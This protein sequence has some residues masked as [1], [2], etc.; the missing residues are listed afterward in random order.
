MTRTDFRAGSLF[1]GAFSICQGDLVIRHAALA[2]TLLLAAGPGPVL[3]QATDDKAQAPFTAGWR[4]GFVI[5]SEKGD[6]RLQIGG[7]LQADARF[8]PGD[9]RETFNDTFLIRRARPSLRARLGQHFE[10]YLN[11]DFAGG[12]LV[13]QD[14]YL[15]TIFAPSFRIR[16]GKMK[17]PFG[18]ERLQSSSHMLFYERALTSNIAPNRDLGV[19]VLGEISRGLVGYA[20]AVTNGVPDGGIADS[21]TSDSKDVTGRI[22]VKPFSRRT[23]SRLRNLGLALAASAGRQSGAAA[24]PSFRTASLQQ[25]FFAYSGAVADGARTRYSPQAFYYHDAFNV[26][27]EYVHSRTPVRRGGD[28]GDVAHRA[29]QIAAAYVLTGEAA[30]DSGSSVR[31]RASFNPSAGQFGAFQ[32]A[33]RYHTLTV[34]DRAFSL[35][36][37]SAGASREANAWTIGLNWYLTPNFKYIFDFERTVFDDGDGSRG[38]ENAILF[39]TQVAF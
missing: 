9:D 11:P 33:A 30:T 32:V 37:T 20:A 24:L 26:F 18:L 16:I 2:V 3:A 8:A 6:F 12:N 13:V 23:D 27:A 5:Q 35:N 19:Q 22:L 39:R 15:D 29:W 28:S 14:A 34:D 17:P 21:D 7:V 25:N 10:F 38:P 36:A 1:L 31:P 4:D